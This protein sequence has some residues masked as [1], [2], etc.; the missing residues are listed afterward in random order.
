MCPGPFRAPYTGS[1]PK[2]GRRGGCAI[3]TTDR[4]GV[5]LFGVVSAA[6]FFFPGLKYHRQRLRGASA[7]APSG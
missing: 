2:A 1:G 6:S 7:E 3:T 4:V 5:L